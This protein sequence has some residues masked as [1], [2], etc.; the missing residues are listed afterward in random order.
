MSTKLKNKF[1]KYSGLK[2]EHCDGV[3]F[4]EYCKQF[5]I[6]ACYET[7]Q[8]SENDFA[9]FIDGYENFDSMRE[10][11][12][13]AVRGSG[14][15]TV[16]V[17][18]WIIQSGVQRIFNHFS[19]CVVLLFKAGSF[20]RNQG[21]IMLFTYVAPENSP[22][23]T[24]EDDGLILLNEKLSEILLHV[25]YPTAELFVAR[26]LNA[27]ISTLQDSFPSMILILSL[28]KRTTQ[29]TRLTCQEILKM[30]HTIV[31]VFPY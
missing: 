21:L 26:D 10:K 29:Q 20:N 27:R 23:Y 11:R 13:R 15:L 17:E 25:H 12:R 14:G 24:E 4:K 9:N 5:D 2:K 16:F 6:I 7:W 28:A 3:V 8:T 22:I 31:L 30:K 18:D 19:E 1:F